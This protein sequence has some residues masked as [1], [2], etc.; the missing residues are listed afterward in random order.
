M[1]TLFFFFF[2][3]VCMLI[4]TLDFEGIFLFNFW[5]NF[6]YVK[7]IHADIQNNFT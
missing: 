5:S 2:A 3:Y 4:T 1:K 7:E 6:N